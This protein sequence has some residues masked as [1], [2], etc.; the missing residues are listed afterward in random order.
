MYSNRIQVKTKTL[1]LICSDIWVQTESPLSRQETARIVRSMGYDDHIGCVLEVK[2]LDGSRP[3]HA[4]L[5]EAWL[6][7]HSHRVT[8]LPNGEKVWD[9]DRQWSESF[10]VDEAW[11]ESQCYNKAVDWALF[12]GYSESEVIG[13]IELKVTYVEK[14]GLAAFDQEF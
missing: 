1:G 2:E 8:Q 10:F 14:V 9:K 11:T 5:V 3:N 13:S 4:T 7:G 12:E 6:P